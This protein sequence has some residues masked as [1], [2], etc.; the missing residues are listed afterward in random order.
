MTN[1]TDQAPGGADL[2]RTALRA[3]R[4]AAR[5]NGN[6]PL[7]KNAPSRQQIARAGRDARE[8]SAL[9]AVVPAMASSQGWALG[10]AQGTMRDNWAQL[11][12]PDQAA[13]WYPA[14]FNADTR[15][16]RVTCD[17]PAWATKLRL[18][19]RAILAKINGARPDT[20][21]ALNIRVSSAAP[22][23]APESA[24]A[25]AT[26]QHRAELAPA[27]VVPPLAESPSYQHLRQQMREQAAARQ[28]T[29]DEAAAAREEILR[30]HYN[31]LREPEHAHR[32]PVEDEQALT[33]A[34]RTRRLRES[35]RAALAVARGHAM[36][37]RTARQPQPA[38]VRGAA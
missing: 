24:P 28:A 37:L 32:P 25:T 13:H 14:G 17:S 10:T 12:G 30:R 6:A 3:A 2:A 38:P 20:V 27:P 11:V 7:K 35:H 23:R 29:L 5:L 18:E 31:K 26:V 21:R 9:A 4:R 34:A 19:Q 22:S 36:P 16:L 8:P 15:T 33:E 1:T